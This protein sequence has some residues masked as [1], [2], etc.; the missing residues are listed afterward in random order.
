MRT[1]G[2]INLSNA[3][4]CKLGITSQPYVKIRTGN[5][6][7]YT[8]IEIN[9]NGKRCIYML[10]P[11]LAQALMIRNHQHLQI[12]Y[13]KSENMLHIGPII[14]ILATSLP[15][16]GEFDPKSMQ[17]ELIYLSNIGKTMKAQIFIFTPAGINWSEQ[18]VKGYNYRHSSPGRGVWVSSTYPLPD[19]V[20]DRIASRRSEQRFKDTRQKL[21]SLPY[22]KYFNPSFLNKWKV[23]QILTTNPELTSYIPETRP[24]NLVNLTEMLDRFPVLYL[25]PG[26]GSLG[27]GIIR[28]KKERDGILHYVTYRRGKIKSFADNPEELLRKTSKQRADRNY[29]VQQGIELAKYRGGI[30]DLRIIYQKNRQGQ[31]QISKKFVR[32]APRGSSISNLASGGR[33]ETSRRVFKHL[34]QKKDVID[35]KNE[36]INRLCRKVADTLES[37]TGLTYGELGLDIGMDISGNPWLIEVNSKPRKTTETELSMSIVKNTFRRPLEY[38]MY[39][40]GF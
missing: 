32:V 15:N 4:A 23:Y 26:D 8:K 5:I 1:V 20:Y 29:I 25:K 36:A 31:W 17:A 22:T 2:K 19:V 9:G 13:D 27:K 11:S 34:Y 39:L 24:L 21:M 18:K 12:R 38:S 7:L 16:H 3:L 33:A 28:V 35:V 14:G 10:S 30:F 40:A 6:V 37:I